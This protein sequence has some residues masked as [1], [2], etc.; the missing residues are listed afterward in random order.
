MAWK[1][2]TQ[3]AGLIAALMMGM[4][5]FSS[6]GVEAQSLSRGIS[7]LQAQTPQIPST[8]LPDEVQLVNADANPTI[9]IPISH[10]SLNWTL[11]KPRI[12]AS[13]GWL[14][15]DRNTVRY[16]LTRQSRTTKEPDQGFE[17]GKTEIV[18]LKM[19]Y[20]AAEF[21]TRGLRH[22]FAYSP[23]SHWDAA[24][25]PG[26]GQNGVNR[27]DSYYTPLILRALQSFDGVVADLKLKQRAAEPP[28]LVVQPAEPPPTIPAAPPPPPTLVVMAPSGAGNNQ[29]IEI[30]ESTLIIRGVAMDDSGLPTV[31]INGSPAALRPK[32]ENVAEFWSDPITLKPGTNPLDI[33]ATSPAKAA[34]HLQFVA[35]FTPKAAPVNPRALG[36]DEIISLLQ[37]GVPSSHVGE[38]VRDRGI[39]FAATP[40]DLNDIR[41]AGG[42]E[43]LIQAIQQAAIAGK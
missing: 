18:D 29:I 7:G 3:H 6:V 5:F 23:E 4:G 16:S 28:P 30:N 32:G 25:T 14:E 20:G 36:K 19:E 34:A 38:L 26:A 33:V 37:G 9:R 31:T 39:K 8:G 15:I 24:D 42:S 22:F 40:G 43:D 41:A 12:K 2:R 17:Y 21:R 13:F 1:K 11:M 10:S 35:N 27:A